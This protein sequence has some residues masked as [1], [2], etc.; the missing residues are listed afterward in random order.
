M[1]YKKDIQ[2]A[3]KLLGN[4]YQMKELDKAPSLCKNISG[5]FEIE[6]IPP[7]P[8][9]V[10]LWDVTNGSGVCAHSVKT[11]NRVSLLDLPCVIEA[12]EAQLRDSVR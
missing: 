6:I 4:D 1:G 8:Y 3:L 11:I 5:K 2:D 12:L 9:T 7:E 10:I